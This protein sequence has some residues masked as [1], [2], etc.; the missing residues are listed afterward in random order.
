MDSHNPSMTSCLSAEPSTTYAAPISK[1]SR[2][3]SHAV[4]DV[5]S[6]D[7]HPHTGPAE[8]GEHTVD[9]RDHR[10]SAARDFETPP[11]PYKSGIAGTVKIKS[12]FQKVAHILQSCDMDC[13]E[14]IRYK[15]EEVPRLPVLKDLFAF[16]DRLAMM[17]ERMDSEFHM[18]DL[19][20][21]E[22][23]PYPERCTE[24]HLE[25]C[26]EELTESEG[27]DV[28]LA[29]MGKP[30]VADPHDDD[31]TDK[32]WPLSRPESVE[33]LPDVE[34]ICQSERKEAFGADARE[35]KHRTDTLIK[36]HAYEEA[37]SEGPFSRLI[38]DSRRSASTEI[39]PEV[40]ELIEDIV[41]LNEFEDFW[42]ERHK[43]ILVITD[44]GV[45]F[46]GEQLARVADYLRILSEQDY[47]VRM[48]FACSKYRLS[49]K[50]PTNLWITSLPR[51]KGAGAEKETDADFE[52]VR[53]N[54]SDS[55]GTSNRYPHEQVSEDLGLEG[56]TS[57]GRPVRNG[58]WTPNPGY[59]ENDSERENITGP[60]RS[61]KRRLSTL[62]SDHNVK[63]RRRSEGSSADDCNER[64]STSKDPNTKEG[65]NLSR[66]FSLSGYKKRV[67]AS[68]T[69]D[70]TEHCVRR[71]CY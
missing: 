16:I 51:R 45:E 25:G 40:Y 47:L 7:G 8:A 14:S 35:R 50:L 9:Q 42:A 17:M 11:P 66:G 1:S 30:S 62:G 4:P 10:H 67:R 28:V 39:D 63:R 31:A 24:V 23:T 12:D 69:R 15:G 19:P 20:W 53:A 56:D 41:P 5:L 71:P 49:A 27:S 70:K 33:P 48:L 34:D 68:R 46:R 37:A 22:W 52:E 13:F 58:R 2:V 21:L 60:V 44:G 32:D 18:E 6:E 55:M 43:D 29:R 57:P 36:I 38:P 54:T 26:P 64:A 59:Q 65:E 61:K 3:G